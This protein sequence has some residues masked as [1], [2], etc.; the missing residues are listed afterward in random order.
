MT[1]CHL[2]ESF[3]LC[4]E[5]WLRS[6]ILNGEWLSSGCFKTTS[7]WNVSF[8]LLLECRRRGGI[9]RSLGWCQTFYVD[10]ADL[11]HL[12]FLPHLS[13]TN[14]VGMS[15]HVQPS[16]LL[17]IFPILPFVP[18]LP[19]LFPS[20]LHS[21]LFV[22]LFALLVRFCWHR[23]SL[24]ILGWP[25]IHRPPISASQVLELQANSTT[26]SLASPFLYR[27]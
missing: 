2:P 16:G 22:H 12:I 5:D 20:F 10:E 17:L 11:E 6:S 9:S 14:I 4:R 27:C 8:L 3:R 7:L 13:N 15:H 21:F 19:F 18:L 24:Y 1:F 25:G 26:P 23:V